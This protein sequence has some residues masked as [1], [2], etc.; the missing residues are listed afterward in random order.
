MTMM[1]KTLFAAAIA[2]LC[3]ASTQAGVLSVNNFAN[4]T[5]AATG[6][7]VLALTAATGG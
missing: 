7:S 5:D 6:M 3:A 2:G 4:G 1:T